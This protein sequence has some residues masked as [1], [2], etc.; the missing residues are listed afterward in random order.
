L[1]GY[2]FNQRGTFDS[3]II[4]CS[5]ITFRPCTHLD[6]KHTIFGKLVG[7]KDVLDKM[8]SVPTDEADYPLQE[9]KMLDVV[10]FVD[11]YEEYEKRLK[12]KLLLESENAEKRN[13]SKEKSEK[14]GLFQ[15]SHLLYTSPLTDALC[16]IRKQLH[17]LVHN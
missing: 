14:V 8:E 9:I 4:I 6:N 13:I 3:L 5:F 15:L 12:R 7:G 16:N 10:V 11:P 2:L 1:V 17:G